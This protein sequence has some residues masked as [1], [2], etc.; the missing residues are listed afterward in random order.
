MS[1]N[2]QTFYWVECDHDGCK[3]QSEDDHAGVF[4]SFI[5]EA[6]AEE[7]WGEYDSALTVGDGA[8]KRHYCE[9]HSTGKTLEENTK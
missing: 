7:H 4:L 6:E 3:A 8:G 1:I 2:S 5:S 9:A